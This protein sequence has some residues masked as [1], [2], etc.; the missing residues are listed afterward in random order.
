MET[1]KHPSSQP[2]GT[3]QGRTKTARKSRW[4][5]L[6]AILL[7][8][9]P[10]TWAQDSP[11]ISVFT[12][13]PTFD[14]GED[15]NW[16]VLGEGPSKLVDGNTSTK[17]G[18]SSNDPWVEF[19]YSSP[20]TPNGYILWT[21]ND[22]MGKRNPRSWTIKGKNSGDADWTTIAE[23][24]NSNGDKLPM[25]NFTSTTFF[26]RNPQSFQYYRFEATRASNGEFQLAELQ[27]FEITGDLH[28]IQYAKVTGLPRF[29][30]YTGSVIPLN[31]TVSTLDGTELVKGTDYTESI[32]K[33]GLPATV[34]EKGDYALTITGKGNYSGSQTI[35]F[36]VNNQA[37]YERALAA[38][39]DGHY[40]RIFTVVDGQKYYVD[41]Y[42]K[43]TANPTSLYNYSFK[44]SKVAGEAYPYSFTM[45][46]FNGESTFYS[47]L[48]ERFMNVGYLYITTNFASNEWNSQVL[49][50]NE[51]GRYAVR[52]S[53]VADENLGQYIVGGSYWTVNMRDDKPVAEYSSDKNYVWQLEEDVQKWKEEAYQQALSAIHRFHRYRVSTEVDGQ[54]YYLTFQGY[55]TAN[56]AESATFLLSAN[57]NNGI[58]ST[59]F[60]FKGLYYFAG[61]SEAT[62]AAL[63]P[64]HLNTTSDDS[65]QLLFLNE[66]GRYAIR[67]TSNIDSNNI[68]DDTYW[69]VNMGANGP[70]AEY[71]FDMNFIW[72]LEEY[73]PQDMPEYE[74][75]LA[76]IQNGH[77][78]RI[79]TEVDGQKYYLTDDGHLTNQTNVVSSFLFGKACEEDYFSESCEYLCSFQIKN[80]GNHFG[81]PKRMNEAELTPG[82]L[83]TF[84]EYGA[85]YNQVLFLN[86]DGR[87]AI[88][89]TD[90]IIRNTEQ[91]RY[92]NTFWTVN[93]GS[94]GPMAEYSFDK[95]YIWQLEEYVLEDRAEYEE[96]LNSIQEDQFYRVSTEVGGHK[97]YLRGDGSLS[98]NE[99]EATSFNF[100]KVIGEEYE[101][102]FKLKNGKIYFTRPDGTTN[103]AMTQG[104]L[105]TSIST[106]SNTWD[107]Q[108]VFLNGEG[109]YAIRSTNAASGSSGKNLYGNTF[110]TV[111]TT[112]DGPVAEY[113]FDRNYVWLIEA[114]PH[115]NHI[116]E[117]TNFFLAGTTFPMFQFKLEN[118]E[119]W[120]VVG[121]DV[122]VNYAHVNGTTW[123]ETFKLSSLKAYQGDGAGVKLY[124]LPFSFT[125]EHPEPTKD[126]VGQI[127]VNAQV[128]MQIQNSSGQTE[129]VIATATLV[130]HWRDI[131]FGGYSE[132]E[133]YYFDQWLVSIP[134]NCEVMYLAR[135]NFGVSYRLYVPDENGNPIYFGGNNSYLDYQI[136]D[137][138]SQ[139]D[140][141][142][143]LE[144]EESSDS[145]YVTANISTLFYEEGYS[146][147]TSM[148]SNHEDFDIIFEIR[149]RSGEGEWEKFIASKVTCKFA[150]ERDDNVYCLLAGKNWQNMLNYDYETLAPEL[151]FIK[152]DYTFGDNWF[153][154][155]E[156]NPLSLLDV[157]AINDKLYG[158]ADITLSCEG[159]E[160]HKLTK[161]TGT[162][163]FLPP[164]DGRK[165]YLDIDFPRYQ[166]HYTLSYVNPQLKH[167]YRIKTY[168]DYN[169]RLSHWFYNVTF[170]KNGQEY[171]D[172]TFDPEFTSYMFTEDPVD[173][174]VRKDLHPEGGGESNIVARI[175][176]PDLFTPIEYDIKPELKVFSRVTYSNSDE[177][178]ER[179]GEN[180]GLVRNSYPQDWTSCGPMLTLNW[181]EI[182]RNTTIV[183]VVDEQ[184]NPVTDATLH[185]ANVDNTMTLQGN[186]ETG[187]QYMPSENGYFI[188]TD[189]QQYAELIEVVAQGFQPTLA[190]MYM[191]NYDYFSRENRNKMRRHT[192]VLHKN[193]TQLASAS[194]ETLKRFGNVKGGQMNAKLASTDLLAMSSGETLVY[195]QNGDYETVTKTVDDQKF[196]DDGWTGTKYARLCGS[197]AYDGDGFDPSALNLTVG[198]TTLSPAGTKLLPKST[199]TTFSQNYC[200]FEFDLVDQIAD[201]ATVR[202][203]VKNGTA[204]L[205]EL[206]KLN[207]NTVDLIALSEESNIDLSGDLLDPDLTDVDNKLSG[208]GVN[209]KDMNKAFDKFN[210]QMPPVLP[211]TVNIEREG[212]YFLV[213]AVCEMNFLPTGRVTDVLDKLD[214]LNY[215]DEQYKACMDA[216]NAAKPE[217]D[218]FFSDIPLA[219]SAFVGV[220]GFLS[221]I[222]HYN[223]ETK[224]IDINFY[225][226]G[227]TMEASAKASARVTFG[228]GGFGV[229]VDARIAST[230][231]LVNRAAALG[232]VGGLPKIDFVLDNQAH[233]KLCAWA[234]AGIDI[235]IAK[236][237]V[238][239]RGGA[240][241]DM[242]TRVVLPTYSQ[243][244]YTGAKLAVR[245]AME[246]YA[247]ARVLFVTKKKKWKIF[248]AQKTWYAPNDATNPLHPDYGEGI[249][250]FSSKNVT[251]SYRRLRRKVIADLGTPIIE[252]VSGM[253]RP[254]YLLGGES[255][256]F[257]NLKTA[258]DYNDDRLQVYAGGS[259][260]DLVN[261]GVSAPMYDF[262]A[263]HNSSGLEVVAFEQV[264]SPI[265]A[266]ELEAMSEETQMK[267][268]TENTGIRVAMRQGSGAW[269]TQA[270]GDSYWNNASVTPAVAVQADG[271][272]AVVWQQGVAKYSTDDDR[273]I[274]GTLMLSRYNGSTWSEPVEIKRLNSRSVPTDY[275]LT[276]KDDSV[277]VMMTLKQDVN[278]PAK[279]P[280]V[281]YV[282]VGPDNLVR[283]RYTQAE[284]SKPQMVHVGGTNLVG[285]LQ[286]KED[287]RDITLSTVNMRGV[288]TGKLSGSLGMERRMVNDFRLVVDD[289]A[290]DLDG[291]A[292]LWNQ[293]D[294]EATTGDDGTTTVLMKNRIYASKLCCHDKQLF[295]SAP[296]EIAT[297]PDDVSLVSMD[298]WLDALDM[299]VAFCVAND[300][301]GAAVLETP[302]E[303]TNA[304][305]YKVDYNAYAVTD[306]K[307]VPVTITVANNGF[308]P[309][310]NVEVVLGDSTYNHAVTL[311]PRQTMEFTDRYPV[312]EDFNGTIDYQVTADFAPANSNSLKLRRRAAA[313]PH[314]IKRNG[315]EMD[316]R[317]VDMALKMLSR[318]VD[319]DGKTTVVAEVNN[320]SLLPLSEGVS[321]KVGLY[322]SPLATEPVGQEVT[323]SY[324]DLYDAS[325][326]KNKTKIVT[327]TAEKP[328]T[329]RTL[330]LRTT[331]VEDNEV[332][333][334]VRPSNNV[335]PVALVGRYMRG[336]VNNDGRVDIAD[337][338]ALVN[339]ISPTPTLPSREGVSYNLIV[340]DMNEDSKIEQDDLQEL[341]NLV[342]RSTVTPA[343]TSQE[344]ELLTNGDF[345]SSFDGW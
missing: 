175:S 254:T 343:P 169:D 293:N 287:G 234:E 229:S 122:T 94:N 248:D 205:A 265:N 78:Y 106:A 257:N 149:A 64:G 105:N 253:A 46:G 224:K 54:K 155:Y 63:T 245:A 270:L 307:F 344:V 177:E 297:M 44:F 95:N 275:Q 237:V 143:W 148:M 41:I 203:V 75:A 80:K 272:A 153:S 13:I 119:G 283:E 209:M 15:S 69:T 152:E 86:E 215:F 36:V 93:I 9:M 189:S 82:H 130:P 112:D 315:T 182:A 90:F 131:S 210:F 227:L 292:L 186:C 76:A 121:D 92:G 212:D 278:N 202:P 89:S 163:S 42:G 43:L 24:D 304:I 91:G 239:V 233:L 140:V 4:L 302:V 318:S 328:N 341:V 230:M 53:N 124:D 264:K 114:D 236:A 251:K 17:Y 246:A 56:L 71:S 296:V 333:T 340:A 327:L 111:K 316:V 286:Q 271:K 74:R 274:D 204:T 222:G 125:E 261:T 334:D 184:G 109:R 84:P 139:S 269:T 108:V 218:D 282:S 300:D 260:S 96:A 16:N 39:Q 266:S 55:L 18:L 317:Q 58:Y 308:S 104:H 20:I 34:M 301:E 142:D 161:F 219:P 217:E 329:S 118:M 337:V 166:K 321:C 59:S 214:N 33:D 322:A 312:T 158:G 255:V 190:T 164:P 83:N 191:W 168:S 223:P 8:A 201:D 113:S 326:G 241:I 151:E 310:S 154:D 138:S 73:V 47:K 12:E 51:E 103:A 98:A 216:V 81:G 319:A 299:K 70:L 323:V 289:D 159:E 57:G 30:E 117:H 60:S 19:H 193:D 176:N 1:K 87:Y 290:T 250:S 192:I 256:L 332:L 7:M 157:F 156:I 72:Q 324:G 123:T 320:A 330:Y 172:F 198:E 160:V 181:E 167:I 5:L 144:L 199:F 231:A 220:K 244:T 67:S 129:S 10:A 100:Q 298:G 240:S 127:L 145:L 280:S 25:A 147:F 325:T 23:V 31:Y 14:R 258:S 228:I 188:N 50:L 115:T 45:T 116:T 61:P 187:G 134:Y 273:Y 27:F 88:R 303:F 285:F 28:D 101:Y 277:L 195:S 249:F 268:V 243:Q 267:T 79:F 306:E 311:L 295:F 120:T 288:P 40:Y 252:K 331:P 22:E 135:D 247:E 65:G 276:M 52:G 99:A 178:W 32:T 170:V 194:L 183:T 26:I 6:I 281:V 49:F 110:W 208:N 309:I 85:W 68:Y 242:Q 342:L 37:D 263:A 235:W 279:Q 171:Y 21:A 291:V 11:A 335:L 150:G 97:Y 339:I 226:G 338:T 196:G 180:K 314:R 136:Y 62:E 284:G 162:F 141:P 173:F 225:D 3:G 185:T 133:S 2:A 107:A 200:L 238:G 165:Y 221:G 48:G 128:T 206:P 126:Q 179:L 345:E 294:Q 77:N 313:R 336:D 259:K 262:S 102:G 305:D 174:Y 66:E 29:N 197:V 207:N 35:H 232:D 213:R 132:A 137:S 211:F 146:N 38:I